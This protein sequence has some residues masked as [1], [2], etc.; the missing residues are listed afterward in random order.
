MTGIRLPYT[1]KREKKISGT[2][3]ALNQD[4]ISEKGQFKKPECL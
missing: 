4:L 1:T 2:E 3:D